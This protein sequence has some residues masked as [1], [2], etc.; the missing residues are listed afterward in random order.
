MIDFIKAMQINAI[1]AQG[2]A[3]VDQI[4]TTRGDQKEKAAAIAQAVINT[5]IAIIKV[6]SA[7]AP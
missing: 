1:K 6:K 4:M 3:L 7:T 5:Q 2:D